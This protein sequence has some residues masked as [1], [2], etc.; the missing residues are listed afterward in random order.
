I[1][2]SCTS[3][4]RSWPHATTA[5]PKRVTRTPQ[6]IVPGR[7]RSSRSDSLGQTVGSAWFM[8]GWAVGAVAS[9]SIVGFSPRSGPGLMFAVLMSVLL[10]DGDVAEPRVDAD[11]ESGFVVARDALRHGAPDAEPRGAAGLVVEVPRRGATA[12]AQREPHRL[13]GRQD[14]VDAA[15]TGLECHL[16]R[17]A[18][19]DHE[20]GE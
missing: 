5:A 7:K 19:G 17:V 20:L 13:P 6:I 12:G 18:L 4:R 14:V 1:A 9:S 8:A 3:K 11:V 16:D 15:E 2:A 10:G